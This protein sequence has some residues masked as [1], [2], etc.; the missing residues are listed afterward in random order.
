MIKLEDHV[1]NYN[2]FYK[3]VDDRIDLLFQAGYVKIEHFG[4]KE[5]SQTLFSLMS[6]RLESEYSGMSIE[7]DGNKMTMKLTDFG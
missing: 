4:D 3:I 2:R 7:M 6:R 1:R 5:D